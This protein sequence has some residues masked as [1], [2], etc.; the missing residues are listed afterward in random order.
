MDGE[1]VAA[2]HEFLDLEAE[3]SAAGLRADDEFPMKT[4]RGVG[5]VGLMKIHRREH[6]AEGRAAGAAQLRHK[7]AGQG[8][9]AVAG[10]LGRF[11]H[12]GG[13]VGIDAG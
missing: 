5:T 9:A 7:G 1:A 3:L 13:G 8:I 4:S 6:P 10:L 2:D 12:A 11:L